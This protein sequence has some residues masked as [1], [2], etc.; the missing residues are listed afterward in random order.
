MSEQ[1]IWETANFTNCRGTYYMDIFV[2]LGFDFAVKYLRFVFFNAAY[3]GL[4]WVSPSTDKAVA[5]KAA[6][7]KRD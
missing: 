1:I 4:S 2:I 3:W 6:K 7:A 5:K